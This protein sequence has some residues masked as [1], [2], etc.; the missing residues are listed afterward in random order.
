MVLR[1][2]LPIQAAYDALDDADVL[3][4]RSVSVK[5]VGI[6]VKIM[7]ACDEHK[8]KLIRPITNKMVC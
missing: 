4:P 5:T 7:K 2:C 3:E 6:A 1:L 8:L